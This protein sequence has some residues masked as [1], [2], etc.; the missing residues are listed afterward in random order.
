MYCSLI[1]GFAMNCFIDMLTKTTSSA[2]YS[3]MLRFAAPLKDHFGIN[4][5][6]YYKITTLG[7]YSYMGS[8][9]AWN[10][11]CFNESLLSDFDCI[12]HPSLLQKGVSL[13]KLTN[14]P[15][16]KKVFD[17]AWEKFQINFNINLVS[18]TADGIEAFG[19]ATHFNDPQADERLINE[20]PLLRLFTK[21]LREKYR[22][23]FEG[24]N[25]HQINLSAEL[26]QNF[27]TASP[28]LKTS[29]N[30]E[31]F[32]RKLGLEHI[33]LLT[34]RELEVLQ[35]ISFGYPA[36]YIA[37]QLQ[38]GTRTVENYLAIIKSKLS[39]RSKLE[40]IQKAQE[41]A[42]SGYFEVPLK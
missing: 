10:E 20:L 19:F 29:Q 24:L 8:N 35:F 15:A 2:A 32:L 37:A 4:H 27:F 5:F 30:R 22:T 13:M 17:I 31:Q 28:V 26:G 38:L 41:I 18:H 12:K 39:C 16:Y 42:A 6:W 23:I 3:S 33:F 40:L 7:H 36:A 1:V 11:Y 14:N 21:L 25:D 34:P 9:A